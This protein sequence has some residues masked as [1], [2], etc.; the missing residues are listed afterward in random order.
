MHA[1]RK[2]AAIASLAAPLLIG[3][4]AGVAAAQLPVAAAP[5]DTVTA[6]AHT[7]T[8]SGSAAGQPGSATALPESLAAGEH[9]TEAG[10]PGEHQDP[11]QGS[12]S[13][14]SPPIGNDTP[15]LPSPMPA[16]LANIRTPPRGQRRSPVLR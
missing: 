16:A 1:K 8:P 3:G 2:L 14:A 5:A 6:A 12:T 11:A 7:A 10:G 13:I 9:Q 15:T 4:A